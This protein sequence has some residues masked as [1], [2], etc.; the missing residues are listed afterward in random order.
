M[1]REYAIYTLI[2]ILCCI[3]GGILLAHQDFAWWGHG[4]WIAAEGLIVFK[5][6]QYFIDIKKGNS[7]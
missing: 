7:R 1:S 6:V 3:G 4:I 5:F 2:T